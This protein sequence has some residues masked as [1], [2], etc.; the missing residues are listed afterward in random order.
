MS[1]RI[2]FKLL[3]YS[4]SRIVL[5]AHIGSILSDY[6]SQLNKIEKQVDSIDIITSELDQWSKDLES[7]VKNKYKSTTNV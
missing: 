3:S 1:G 2:W 5:T 7:K 6:L 4:T